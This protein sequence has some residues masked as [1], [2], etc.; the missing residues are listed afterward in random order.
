MGIFDSKFISGLPAET[1]FQKDTISFVSAQTTYALTTVPKPLSVK[2]VNI[3]G[4]ELFEGVDFTISGS[5]IVFILSSDRMSVMET[6][7]EIE[8]NYAF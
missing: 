2:A 5:N 3:G 4:A 6:G 8:C 7:D 1:S